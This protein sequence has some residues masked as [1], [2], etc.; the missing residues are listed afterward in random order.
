M[1]YYSTTKSNEVL[2]HA[3]TC[4]NL[5]N[6]TLGERSQSQRTVVPCRMTPCIGI[7]HIHGII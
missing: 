4:T 5:E 1:E 6:I 3:I 2:M 7:L